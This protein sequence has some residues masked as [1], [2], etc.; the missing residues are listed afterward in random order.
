MTIRIGI[1]GAAKIAPSAIIFP[2]RANTQFE[3]MAVGARDKCRAER[4]AK[5]HGI[6]HVASDYAE[7]VERADVDVVYNA[8]PPN[9]HKRWTIAAL[10]AGKPVLCEKPLAM[11]SAEAR[12]MVSRAR[13]AEL[14]LVEAFHYRFHWVMRRAIEIVHSGE[15]GTLVEG[16]I[17]FHATIPYRPGELRWMS[18]LGGGAMMDL[19][20]YC[21]HALRALS[22]EEPKIVNAECDI[23]RGVDEATHANLAFPSGLRVS[24]C[25]A[26]NEPSG[27]MLRLKGEKGSLAISNFAAPQNGCHFTVETGG[28]IR[29]ESVCGPSTYDEQ[30]AHFGDVLLRGADPITS[31]DDVIA[32]MAAIDAIYDAAGYVREV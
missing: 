6:P 21:V 17:T 3:V 22:G 8:L 27:A 24:L 2:A 11:N 5:K 32:N 13:T 18:E 20:C 12:D 10:E 7:L 25:V 30:L 23:V 15:L 9:L 19:G 1:L 16:N 31:G 29:E 14:Q 26:M 4:F 28:K